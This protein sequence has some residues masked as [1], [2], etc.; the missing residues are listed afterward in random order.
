MGGIGNSAVNHWVLMVFLQP[1]VTEL[2]I[3]LT[4]L[5]CLENFRQ[6]ILNIPVEEAREEYWRQGT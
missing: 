3:T 1:A 2:S 4:K 5:T 6:N